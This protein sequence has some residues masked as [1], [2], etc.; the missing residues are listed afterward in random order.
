M[1]IIAFVDGSSYA[2]S[3]CDHAA[4]A[5]AGAPEARVELIHMLGR[6]DRSSQPVDLSGSLTLGARSTLMEDLARADA[7]RA[8]L[9]QARG[10]L[11]LENA[12]DRLQAAG[13]G[14]VETRQR[15][16]DI[17]HAVRDYEAGA[18]LLVLG[19]RGEA[20]GFALEHLG[21]NLER[22]LRS[23]A[24]PVLV[25]NRA[26]RP[27]RRCLLAYDGG[28]SVARA[29]HFLADPARFPDLA[30]HLLNVGPD[31]SATRAKM[32]DAARPLHAAGRDVEIEI[33]DGEPDTVI[34]R[35][36]ETG[37]IDLLAIGA[38]GHSRI[39]NLFIGSTTTALIRGCKVPVILVR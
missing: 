25:A 16:D 13:V 2:A 15:N 33:T 10:R 18:D 7:E 19:K 17:L 39:R 11:I 34:E 22:I 37:G 31:T 6:R 5:A 1:R 24:K 36:V 26:F 29:V 12:R 28:E 30:F 20:S 32:E 8:K 9:A 14:N 4:W 21:S 38:H 35:T 3:V 23:A 27:I